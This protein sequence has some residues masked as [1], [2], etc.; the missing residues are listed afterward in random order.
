[1][2]DWSPVSAV[3]WLFAS[4]PGATNGLL[5]RW[6][7]LR[8]L[9]L[10]YYSAFFSLV[11]QIKGLIGPQGILPA[12]EYLHA[13]TG[14]FGRVGYWYA[15]TLLWLSSGR[16]MLT[17]ICWVGM[18]ASL[19]QIAVSNLLGRDDRIAAAGVGFVAARNAGDLLCVF[20]FVRERGAGFFRVPIRRNAAGGRIYFFVFRAGRI[21][22]TAGRAK[23]AFAS[24]LVLA[25][26]GMLPNLF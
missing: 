23:P 4:E 3:R 17:A 16:H 8:A 20:P 14:Q 19:L 6:I 9:G 1:M 15:P 18:I 13:V 22:A 10:I 5:P 25:V 11:F 2:K 12:G 26:V 21:P 24:E 7:F